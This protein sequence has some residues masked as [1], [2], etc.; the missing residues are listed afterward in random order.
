MKNTLLTSASLLLQPSQEVASEFAVKRDELAAR[1]NQ[2]MDQRA[3]LDRLIGLENQQMARD[4]NKNFSRFMQAQFTNYNAEVM[5]DTVLWVFRAYRSHGFKTT[6][7][8]A[9]LNIWTD[10]LREE[11]SPRAFEAV[12]PFYEWL[13]VNIPVFTALSDEALAHD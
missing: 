2:I 13:I 9:N 10:M 4:N 12:Y 1:G 11:L 8:A 3:D 6:Y 5:V 7:W